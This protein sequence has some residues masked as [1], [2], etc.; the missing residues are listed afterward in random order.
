MNGITRDSYIDE[1]PPV[2]K[3]GTILIGYQGVGKSTVAKSD[4]DFIDLESGSF[5][6]DGKR[7]PLWYKSYCYIAEHLCKQGYNVFVSSHQVVRE[8]LR[9]SDC[10]VMVIYPSLYLKDRWIERLEKR[11]NESQLE[12]DY[13]AWK[14]AE[15]MYNQNISDLMNEE[16]FEHIVITRIPY[17]LMAKI[18]FRIS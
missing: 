17:D 18:L 13:K 3:S 11:Y 8:Q 6:V 5:W 4:I 10:R 15:E 2:L 16:T 9:N 12:K 14:N 7:D 1:V